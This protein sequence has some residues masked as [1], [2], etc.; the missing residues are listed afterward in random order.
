MQ[1]IEKRMAGRLKNILGLF[2]LSSPPQRSVS[3]IQLILANTLFCVH[4]GGKQNQ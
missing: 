3:G 4:R 2:L 1:D